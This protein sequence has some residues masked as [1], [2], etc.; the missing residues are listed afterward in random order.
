M[1]SSYRGEGIGQVDSFGLQEE[2]RPAGLESQPG[3]RKMACVRP[4]NEEVA[5][6]DAKACTDRL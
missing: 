1:D 2:E 5:S 4:A 6:F 3:C